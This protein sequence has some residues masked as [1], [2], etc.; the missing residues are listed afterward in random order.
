[1]AP[2]NAHTVMYSALP[3]FVEFHVSTYYL[4]RSETP[5]GIQKP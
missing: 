5:S 3:Q 1:M 4:S 2:D